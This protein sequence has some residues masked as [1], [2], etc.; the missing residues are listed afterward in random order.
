MGLRT[1][2]CARLSGKTSCGKYPMLQRCEAT[3]TW[4]ALSMTLQTILNAVQERVRR[5]QSR[6]ALNWT[7]RLFLPPR[8]ALT[9]E[10]VEPLSVLEDRGNVT[11]PQ[12]ATSETL[13]EIRKS[14][15]RRRCFDPWRPQIGQFALSDTPSDTNNA[16][17]IDVQ[18]VSGVLEIANHPLVLSVVSNYLGCKP[19]IDDIIAWW[20]LPGRAQPKQ[21]QF[22]H[23]DND[24]VRFVKLFVYLTNVSHD[25]GA[26]VFVARSHRHNVLLE[27]RKRYGD[28]EVN[29]RFG[30][31]STLVM[32]GR[33]GT[34]FLEDTF[35]LHKGTVPLRSP[36]LL[37]Q[38]RYTSFPSVWAKKRGGRI[39][40]FDDYMNRF[41]GRRAAGR[42]RT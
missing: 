10:A 3:I 19:T 24:A 26:H 4:A 21:E 40:G 18:D 6:A 34:A 14:L 31:E 41:I 38:V 42:T 27:R 20:S 9:S 28:H 1:P 16:H 15:E 32:T 5:H 36:R 22:F 12:L 33:A 23:R 35:G 13:L 8:L 11:L 39:I 29:S 37:L 30:A 25:D 2:S 7:I 17:V